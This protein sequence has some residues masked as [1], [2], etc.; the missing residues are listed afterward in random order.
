MK[1]KRHKTTGSCRVED[2]FDVS[3][4]MH[5]VCLAA[6][7]CLLAARLQVQDKA[8]NL[9]TTTDLE[10]YATDNGP[11]GASLSDN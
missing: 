4:R 11:L 2:Q 6:I 8:S 9:A 10:T 7:A 1:Q 5:R 3:I